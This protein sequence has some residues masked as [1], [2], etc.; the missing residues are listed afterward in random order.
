M[1]QISL[2]LK[3]ALEWLMTAQTEDEQEKVW[4]PEEIVNADKWIW[5]DVAEPLN[6]YTRFDIAKILIEGYEL[7]QEDEIREDFI[8]RQGSGIIEDNIYCGA[9]INTLNKLN[10]T[11]KGVND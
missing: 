4:T 9:V 1:V 3:Q 10:I 11:L 2:E 8:A 6:E 7:S 5:V